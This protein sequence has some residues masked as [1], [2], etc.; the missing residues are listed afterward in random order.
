VVRNGP[1]R[2]IGDAEGFAVQAGGGDDAGGPDGESGEGASLKGVH[3][4]RS[5]D[6]GWCALA[7]DHETAV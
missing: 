4:V 7:E 2:L 3:F 6:A 1:L 5:P